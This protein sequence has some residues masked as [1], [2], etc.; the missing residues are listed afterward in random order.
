MP[1]RL[2]ADGDAIRRGAILV[3]PPDSHME[4]E[5]LWVRLSRGPRENRARPAVDP[6]FRSAARSY[7][8]RAIAVVLSGMLGDGAAGLMAVRQAGGVG[9]VQDPA[10]AAFRGMT[11][12]ALEVAGADHVVRAADM[13]ATLE[14]LIAQEVD[15]S[16]TGQHGERDP[17]RAPLPT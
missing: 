2:A 11:T 5:E 12:R 16:M 3:A 15:V 17:V 9:I 10:D 7:G 14:E 8:P 4:I 13:R 6:L 1:A